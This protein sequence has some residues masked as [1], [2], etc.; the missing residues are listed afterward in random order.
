MASSASQHIQ[1][2]LSP[3]NPGALT[4]YIVTSKATALVPISCAWL[5]L[6]TRG[7]L[8]SPPWTTVPLFLFPDMSPSAFTVV[9]AHRYVTILHVV[10]ER[11]VCT[12]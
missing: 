3:P 7:G 11:C 12:A 4:I 6:R 2:L 1:P 5:A 9:D 10:E 8:A